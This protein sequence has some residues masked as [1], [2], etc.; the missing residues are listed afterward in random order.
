MLIVGARGFAKEVLEVVK[1]LNDLTDL[2]FYDDVNENVPLKLHDRF[3]ILKSLNDASN[4]FATTDQR[5]TLG[6]GNPY[7]RKTLYEKFSAAG[8]HLVSTV[9]PLANLGSFD[10]QIGNGANILPGAIFSNGTTLGMGCIVYYNATITHDCIVGDFVQV[11]PGATLL[12]KCEV[13]DY[14]QVGANSTVMP[15]VKLGRNVIVGAGAVVTTHIPDN[16]VVTGIPAQI[17]KR[18]TPLDI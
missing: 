1:Q 16:C 3:P 11:S 8:G 10:V 7:L 2:V 15:N 4:Y 14:S 9:S 6:I 17:K 13:G 5:F 18:L 12:G